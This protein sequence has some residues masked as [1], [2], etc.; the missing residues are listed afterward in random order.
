MIKKI[1][2]VDFYNIDIQMHNNINKTYNWYQN[3]NFIVI[4]DHL[5]ALNMQHVIEQR[6]LL[7]EC[8]TFELACVSFR[9]IT[10]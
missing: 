5:D 7:I 3:F 10:C 8:G 4:Y 1:R 9:Q 6:Y 2:H